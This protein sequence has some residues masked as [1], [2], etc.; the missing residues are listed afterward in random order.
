MSSLGGRCP[1]KL[2]NLD[3]LFALCAAE[4][5][6]PDVG[7]GGSKAFSGSLTPKPLN[8]LIELARLVFFLFAG[9]VLRDLF[10]IGEELPC[11]L[12]ILR[13]I[14]PCSRDG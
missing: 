9:L 6:A 11:R 10:C 12:E 4:F 8:I 7:D 1:K 13:T 3:G 2:C 5:K 14:R